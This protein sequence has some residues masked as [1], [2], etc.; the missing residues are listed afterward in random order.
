MAPSLALSTPKRVEVRIELTEE[1]LFISV[2]PTQLHQVILNLV[3]NAVEAIG[4]DRDGTITIRLGECWL[5]SG[6]RPRRVVFPPGKPG[7]YAFLEVADTGCGMAHETLPKIFDPF[8]TTKFAGRGLGLSAV[9][10]TLR[11]SEGAVSVESA[12]GQGSSFQ[13]FFP[14]NETAEISEISERASTPVISQGT[15]LFVDDEPMLRELAA[16]ILAEVG[17]AV[18][19]AKDG[20]EAVET[21]NAAHSIIALVIL[22]LTMPRLG[23]LEA[24]RKIREIDFNAKVVLSSGY[25]DHWLSE[26][27]DDLK[28]EG[29][30]HKPYKLNDLCEVVQ[31]VLQGG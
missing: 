26:S 28:P 23:G 3:T 10:G 7:R 29:F 8:F 4:E 31:R 22:D 20:M 15:I 11:A 19:Q 21:Y 24:F 12:P 14:L 2:D 25:T 9:M 6:A 27:P 18:L 1:P 13:V 16:E 5:E 17:F 30:L